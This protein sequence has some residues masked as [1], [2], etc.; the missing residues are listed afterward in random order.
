[1][2]IAVDGY[3]S[4]GKS[5]LAKDLAQALDFTYID[6]GAMYRAVTLYGLRNGVT[7]GKEED[8][9]PLLDNIKIT[10]DKDAEGKQIILLNGE[11]VSKE[12]RGMEVSRSVSYYAKI[13]EVRCFLVAQQRNYAKN[14]SIVMDGRDI[15]T[16][17]FPD[18]E[19]KIFL[20]AN[21]SIRAQ[22]RYDEMRAKG[23]DVS[24]EEILEN[25]RERDYIDENRKESPLRKASDAVVLDNS[26]LNRQEQLDV[27]LQKVHEIRNT[28]NL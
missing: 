8:I 12:I 27:V 3:S 4:C 14:G 20:T 1:M 26:Q 11:D 10:F 25:L 24:M 23:K 18:A 22:R 5:T 19:L 28:T 9:I 7:V 6:S 13:K 16:V 2:I 21:Q 17:V 15:G